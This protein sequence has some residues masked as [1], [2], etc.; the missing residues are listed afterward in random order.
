MF[1]STLEQ[2]SQN[3]KVIYDFVNTYAYYRNLVTGCVYLSNMK[4]KIKTVIL[5]VFGIMLCVFG[6]VSA[7]FY[8]QNATFVFT[9]WGSIYVHAMDCEAP[10]D[11]L[12]SGYHD[13]PQDRYTKIDNVNFFLDEVDTI[14]RHFLRINGAVYDAYVAEFQHAGIQK[15]N[16]IL[17]TVD[18]S[19]FVA[20]DEEEQYF[21]DGQ[22]YYNYYENSIYVHSYPTFKACFD[23]SDKIEAKFRENFLKGEAI[24]S[25]K[26]PG[27]RLNEF[28]LNTSEEAVLYASEEHQIFLTTGKYRSSRYTPYAN[29]NGVLY[30]KT[31]VGQ[32]IPVEGVNPETFNYLFPD[33]LEQNFFT[34]GSVVVLKGVVLDVEKDSFRALT[35]QPQ[36]LDYVI[37]TDF[38]ASD[39]GVFRLTSSGLE[40]IDADAKTFEVVDTDGTLIGRI[41]RDKDFLYT[42]DQESLEINKEKRV[43]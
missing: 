31:D 14:S 18:E 13:V 30:Y 29:L 20:V 33:L 41:Y 36:D 25:E 35:V 42:I 21:T 22:K 4:I 32:F 2:N 38:F 17:N 19:R 8:A 1:S 34:D 6:A 40:R 9:P 12:V 7:L 26:Y 23:V 3:Y 43:D 24:E 39:T 5:V 16:N 11:S 15:T 10:G 28:T 37:A 27:I